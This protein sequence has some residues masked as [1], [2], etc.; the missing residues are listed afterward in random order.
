MYCVLNISGIATISDGINET[1]MK[2]QL[3]QRFYLLLLQNI[4]RESRK[5]GN[6]N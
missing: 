6:V 2:I 1:S 4:L 5:S 3:K